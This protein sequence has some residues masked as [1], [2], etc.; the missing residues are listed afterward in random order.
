MIGAPIHRFVR[1][2]NY[3]SSIWNRAANRGSVLDAT[4]S[5][6]EDPQNGR[7][8]YLIGSTHSSTR[9]ALRTKELVAQVKPDVLYVQTNEKWWNIVKELKGIDNQATLNHYNDVLD[10]ANQFKVD[11]FFRG[12]LFKL[13]FYPWLVVL[14]LIKRFPSDFHPF[15]P[16]LEMKY[17]IEEGQKAGAKVV[18]GGLAL[19][20]ST[21]HGLYLERRMG[22]F[23]LFWRY[24]VSLHNELWQREYRD[25]YT[26]L[27]QHGGES[28]SETLDRQTTNWWNKLFE[29]YAPR[30]KKI[31]V[32]QRDE[33]IFVDLYKSKGKKIVAVVNQWHLEGIEAFWR[34][35]TGT[36]AKKS[37]I[38]PVGDFDIDGH[39][40]QNLIND[41][42]RE[43]VSELGYT[44]P[45]TWQ[46]YLTT[47]H[48]ENFEPER[49]RHTDFFHWDDH[50]VHHEVH[51]LKELIHKEIPHDLLKR[52]WKSFPNELPRPYD[53]MEGILPQEGT[54]GSH[55]KS[56][57][58]QDKHAKL[59]SSHKSKGH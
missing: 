59:D 39:Q 42:L 22:P 18:F 16:G 58:S 41:A 26:M 1:N 4:L 48:K 47:Y 45:A 38:N 13:R 35:T 55:G 23:G 49:T 53:P 44:E 19:D 50:G 5:K 37:P 43:I 54:Q 27:E 21:V 14:N 56:E 29:K 36:E 20:P 25:Q 40:E 52:D 33:R 34:H 10:S 51:G 24:T 32:D 46:N 12:M 15:T 17:A 3:A 7:T 57:V 28:Y 11:N 6:L 2:P 8:L 9:L 30:Q 31:I